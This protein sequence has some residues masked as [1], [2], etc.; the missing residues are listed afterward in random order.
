MAENKKFLDKDGL[1]YFYDKIKGEY[2]KSSDLATVATSGSY[3]DLSDKPTIPTNTINNLV[4]GIAEGSIRSIN[5]Y[6]DKTNGLLGENA[7]A[8]GDR[9]IASGEC[10]YAEGYRTLAASNYQHV[11]GKF[12]FKDS[13]NVFAHIVGNGTSENAR[14]NAYVLD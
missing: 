14:S 9:T 3:N 1:T 6:D 7:Q 11:Q 4:D 12:N 2:V 8:F 13:S 5:A 10:A